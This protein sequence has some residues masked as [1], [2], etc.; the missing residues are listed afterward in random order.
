M[1]ATSCL[2]VEG[3]TRERDVRRASRWLRGARR[4]IPQA[5]H[6]WRSMALAAPMMLMTEVQFPVSDLAIRAATLSG[7][8]EI[9]GTIGTSVAT[10]FGR[11]PVTGRVSS[12]YECDGS[13][14][15][16]VRYRWLVRLGAR[17]K[18]IGLVNALEGQLAPSVLSEC[19]LPVETLSGY[20]RI[21]GGTLAGHVM[22]GTDSIALGG[23]LRASGDTAYH[24]A[25]VPDEG[26]PADSAFVTFYVR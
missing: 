11:L 13:F 9:H 6:G 21:T 16:T 15:G 23:T 1:Q 4:A 18:G 19:E 26:T 17:V 10:P 8:H 22:S 2:S 12:R 25:V 3:P 14:E 5:A 7:S 24:A 20:F